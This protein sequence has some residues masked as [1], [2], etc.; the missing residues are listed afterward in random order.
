MR[1]LKR[2]LLVSMTAFTLQ[3][4]AEEGPCHA[5][6]EKFCAGD[7]KK[8][9]QC[10]KSHEAEL[11]A[12]CKAHMAKMMEMKSG[13]KEERKEMSEACKGDA[14]TLCKNVE[15][16]E[17]RIWKCLKENQDKVSAACKNEFAEFKAEKKEAKEGM[18]KMM[19]AKKNK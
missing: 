11:S 7:Q 9:G 2:F 5:D 19:K 1:I 12:E 16:G 15:K 18:K 4:F 14:E 6:R 8:V 17:G 3:G 10:L 13:L